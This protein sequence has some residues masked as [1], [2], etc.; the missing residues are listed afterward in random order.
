MWGGI[1]PQCSM[2]NTSTRYSRSKPCSRRTR[3]MTA[4]QYYSKSIR[5]CPVV[6]L[7]WAEK[8]TTSTTFWRSS[9]VS[10]FD[11]AKN[12]SYGSIPFKGCLIGYSGFVGSSILRQQEFEFKYRSTTIDDV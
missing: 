5:N 9:M 2:P 8:S 4:G 12:V 6:T 11:G 7:Y 1:F 10:N 3:G